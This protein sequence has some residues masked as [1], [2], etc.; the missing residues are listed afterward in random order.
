[1]T[2]IGFVGLGRMGTPIARNL[3]AAGFPLT[4][5]NRGRAAADALAADIPAGVAESPAAVA[6]ASDVVMTMVSD[7]A[8]VES[9]YLGEQGLASGIRP[10]AAAVDL[11]TVAPATSRR[12][13]DALHRHGA[14]F[15]DAPVSGSTAAAAS[16][17]LIV[18]AG[19]ADAAVEQVRPV[20][21]SIASAVHHLG[22]VGSGAA[23]KLAV[24]AI[25]YGLM[26]A[27]AEGLVLAE[28]AGIDR[29]AAYEVIASS[30][31]AAPVVHY[32]RE[33]F[34]RPDEG[35]VSFRLALGVKDLRL[36]VELA[37]QVGAPMPQ[38][39][40]NLEILDSAATGGFADW[41]LAGVAEWLRRRELPDA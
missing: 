4:L 29:L 19:G 20:L 12:L 38:T 2:R 18:M 26:G 33:V 16:R 40:R 24:N 23:M 1:L 27:L 14:V 21:E 17:S 39:A 3:A 8:A 35:Q 25:V 6:R 30:A 10:G 15:V 5:W 22:P 31:V 9:V 32:R 41:D 7:D 37:Q 11:S 28:R 13:A 34:E 36:I